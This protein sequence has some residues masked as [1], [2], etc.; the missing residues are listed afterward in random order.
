MVFVILVVL[1]DLSVILTRSCSRTTSKIF[2]TKQKKFM[3]RV[4]SKPS[5]WRKKQ[6]LS[7]PTKWTLVLQQQT[8]TLARKACQLI[9]IIKNPLKAQNPL[10]KWVLIWR[11]SPTGTM[12]RKTFSMKSLLSIR[13][14][15]CLSKEL[16]LTINI[17]LTSLWRT[18]LNTPTCFKLM[19]RNSSK[20]YSN[21]CVITFRLGCYVP[22]NFKFETTNNK[23]Y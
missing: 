18:W 7:I 8:L 9:S 5:T 23:N 4:T 12:E 17:I 13:S 15:R 22:T 10:F 6:R 21:W 1:T 19:L 11:A 3:L 14:T 16:R 20:F 2:Q